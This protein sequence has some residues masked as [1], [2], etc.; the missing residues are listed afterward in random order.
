VVG[1]EFCAIVNG[2]PTAAVLR[3]DER[4]AAVQ[5]IHPVA[6]VHVLVIPRRHYSA[7]HEVDDA[8]LICHLFRVAHEVADGHGVAES[9]YR[10]VL[11]TGPDALQSMPHVHLHVI[12]GRRMGWPPG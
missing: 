2:E 9:G 12:G 4:V 5:D 7:I 6:P 10:L 8:D 11:N 1:C 3:R